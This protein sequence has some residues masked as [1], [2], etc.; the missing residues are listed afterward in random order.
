MV[1]FFF[2]L[3]AYG[4]FEDAAGQEG[5]RVKSEKLIDSH[6]PIW[7]DRRKTPK[8]KSPNYENLYTASLARCQSSSLSLPAPPYLPTDFSRRSR[9]AQIVPENR[10][11]HRR[12]YIAIYTARRTRCNCLSARA[13]C[14]C[15]CGRDESGPRSGRRPASH[16]LSHLHAVL[17]QLCIER[18]GKSCARDRL[19]E[20]Y[21]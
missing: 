7:T 1:V 8:K 15:C 12:L 13:A 9:S 21:L 3:L 16:A 2:V 18:S 14:V 11:I 19:I 6:K 5:C 10:E 4:V 17:Q 20:S